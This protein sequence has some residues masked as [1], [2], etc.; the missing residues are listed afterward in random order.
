MEI[1]KG[2]WGSDGKIEHIF[3]EWSGGVRRPQLR[4]QGALSAVHIIRYYN[5]STMT[6]IFKFE[7][8]VV[9]QVVLMKNFKMRR[10]RW[11]FK[12]ISSRLKIIS[13]ANGCAHVS[14]ASTR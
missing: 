12:N 14:V 3:Q 9:A 8:V 6:P 13:G 7:S 2:S 11:R 5:H 4:R 10:G 1:D